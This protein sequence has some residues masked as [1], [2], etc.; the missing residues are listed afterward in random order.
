MI[1]ERF[2]SDSPDLVVTLTWNT[3]RTD[4]DLHVTDPTGEEC[5]YKHARTK[6]G[7]GITEDV[8]QGYGPE[9]FLLGHAVPGEYLVR[10][11]YYGSDSLR[12]TLRSKVFATVFRR[13]AREGERVTRHELL[14]DD[15][16]DFQEVLR[17]DWQ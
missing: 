12:R 9:M 6:I 13:W 3:D 5:S 1:D 7:G 4:V 16:K 8:T 11:H 17:F 14:L 2:L 15:E 10:V